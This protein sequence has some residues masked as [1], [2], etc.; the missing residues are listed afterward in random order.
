MK[1]V[2]YDDYSRQYLLQAEEYDREAGD[3]TD[4]VSTIT[5]E[6]SAAQARNK[7]AIDE[8]DGITVSWENE[9][10]EKKLVQQAQSTMN[11]YYQLLQQ[12]KAAK[13]SRELTEANVNATKNR[14]TVQMATQADVLAAQQ[15]LEDADAQIVAGI[16][17]FD[18]GKMEYPVYKS[19]EDCKE[20]ADVV[21]DFA[22]AKAEDAL[23][24]Y[25]GAHKLPV[26]VCTTGLS[27]EP[28]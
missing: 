9:L 22:S 7:A 13:K 20:E 8:K 4:D 16:D 11:S 10:A 28:I 25:C 15:S 24:D 12:L 19:L 2:D 1:G 26:V 3:A 5:A 6:M 14:Q 21:I 17:P 18:N 27:E 23:L